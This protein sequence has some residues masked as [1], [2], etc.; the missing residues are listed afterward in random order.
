[1][2]RDKGT[3]VIGGE[4][5]AARTAR[6]LSTVASPC[7]EV[8]PGSSGLP[9]VREEPVGAGPLV[10][11]AAGA[12]ALRR[13]IPGASA[14]RRDI[15]GASAPPH[16][17]PALVVACDLPRLDA[18]LLRWLAE[19]PAPGSVVPIWD[20]RPQPLCARWS[21][22]ALALAS[23]LA[24]GGARAMQAL[25]DGSDAVLVAPPALLATALVDV[26]TPEQLAEIWRVDSD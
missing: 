6:L 23:E 12:S 5:L 22:G 7:V 14:L 13:G 18:G 9:A 17:V 16:F 11:L 1:M 20:G 3:I 26:D 21:A 24:A 2:G 10:A 25:A 8:G 4:T 15:P 19:H